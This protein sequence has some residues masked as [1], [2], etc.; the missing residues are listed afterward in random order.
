MGE[1]IVEALSQTLAVSYLTF[2]LVSTV[3]LADE[4]FVQGY[5]LPGASMEQEIT[6][7]PTK[8]EYIATRDGILKRLKASDKTA[9]VNPMDG[10]G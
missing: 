5:H 2:A 7:H 3:A 4:K 1:K 6:Y 9:L 8:A 10:P